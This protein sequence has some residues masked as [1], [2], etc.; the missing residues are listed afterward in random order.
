MLFCILLNIIGIYLESNYL[1]S[2]WL[3]L[4]LAFNFAKA[5]PEKLLI[6]T[7]GFITKEIPCWGTHPCSGDVFIQDG[8]SENEITDF[9]D[10]LENSSWA[11]ESSFFPVVLLWYS[12]KKKKK[13]T[14]D[15]EWSNNLK[16]SINL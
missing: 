14:S 1:E 6:Y 13:S 15:F 10:L 11:Q 5:G 16:F 12:G 2:V 9:Q 4:N 7:F 8:R 3:S